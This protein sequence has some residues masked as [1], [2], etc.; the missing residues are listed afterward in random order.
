MRNIILITI[1]IVITF[2]AKAKDLIGGSFE[3]NNWQSEYSNSSDIKNKESN[4]YGKATVEFKGVSF[5]N[6]HYS[7]SNITYDDFSYIQNG[8]TFYYEIYNE[9]NITLDLGA[10]ITNISNGKFNNNEFEAHFINLYAGT[11]IKIPESNIV[12]FSNMSFSNLQSSNILDTII[13]ARYN[14]KIMR[15]LLGLQAGY[16]YQNFKMKDLD[17]ITNTIKSDGFFLGFK[18]IY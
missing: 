1:L 16:K 2:N 8:L 3:Y 15:T 6:F 4:Y 18:I 7:F 11:E 10:G 13:G 17:N 9:N 5:P 14:F 12:V